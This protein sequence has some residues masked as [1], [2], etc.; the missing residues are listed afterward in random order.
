MPLTVP[1]PL[2][3]HPM[4]HPIRSL[5]WGPAGRYSQPSPNQALSV[6]T[7]SG[8]KAA[9]AL[10]TAARL[11]IVMLFF[12]G[13]CQWLNHDAIGCEAQTILPAQCKHRDCIR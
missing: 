5:A 13:S 9:A 7:Q 12:L 11:S 8:T 6:A 10:L 3:P 2:V 4:R 1:V